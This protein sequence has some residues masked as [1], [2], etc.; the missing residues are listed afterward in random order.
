MTACRKQYDTN[1]KC[2]VARMLVDRDAATDNIINKSWVIF[3]KYLL[4]R[5]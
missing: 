4:I 1:F 2:E 3:K 5:D